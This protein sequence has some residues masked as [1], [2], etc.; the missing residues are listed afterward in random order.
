MKEVKVVCLNCG[1]TIHFK[2]WFHW[3]WRCPFH[4]FG[5][6]RVKCPHCG[7]KSYTERV[8]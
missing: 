1:N 4:W 7:N 3:V 8:K 6:R 5:K 2:N